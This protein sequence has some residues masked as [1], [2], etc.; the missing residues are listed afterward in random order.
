MKNFM[1]KTSSKPVL[2]I[3]ILVFRIKPCQGG[4]EGSSG[5]SIEGEED[6]RTSRGQHFQDVEMSGLIFQLNRYLNHVPV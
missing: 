1:L 5:W 6:G 4:E 2:S 3:K